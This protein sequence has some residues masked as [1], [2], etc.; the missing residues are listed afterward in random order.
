MST[1]GTT[2][3]HVDRSH[4]GLTFQLT[5]PYKNQRNIEWNTDVDKIRFHWM[6]NRQISDM[7]PKSQLS[8]TEFNELSQLFV[9]KLTTKYELYEDSIIG[10]ILLLLRLHK[11]LINVSY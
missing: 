5:E 11:G 10:I 8:N 6:M 7:E 1:P 2:H 4:L 3:R 9:R